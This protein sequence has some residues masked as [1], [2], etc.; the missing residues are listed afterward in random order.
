MVS[1]VWTAAGGILH[2]LEDLAPAAVGSSAG[3]VRV[4]SGLA[5]SGMWC[6]ACAVCALAGGLGQHGTITARPR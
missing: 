1:V 4:V 6:S 3:C 5:A 2:E